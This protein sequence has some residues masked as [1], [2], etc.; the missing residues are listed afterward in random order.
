MIHI[1]IIVREAGG[2]ER[3]KE[4]EIIIKKCKTVPHGISVVPVFFCFFFFA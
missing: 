4:S 3:K 1:Y 2:K